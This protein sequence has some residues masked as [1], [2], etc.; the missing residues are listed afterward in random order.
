MT[1]AWISPCYAVVR[2]ADTQRAEPVAHA[3]DGAGA[4]EV[5]ADAAVDRAGR[6]GV[7]ADGH[8]AVGRGAVRAREDAVQGTDAA[9][10]RIARRAEAGVQVLDEAARARRG[11]ADHEILRDQLTDLHRAEVQRRSDDLAGSDLI[12]VAAD[13]DHLATHIGHAQSVADA[14]HRTGGL[15]VERHGA[16]AGARYAGVDSDRH[17]AGAGVVRA[18]QPPA[19][20]ADAGG[21]AR[22]RTEAGVQVFAERARRGR[23]G[24]CQHLAAASADALIG[25]NHRARYRVAGGSVVGRGAGRAGDGEQLRARVLEVVEDVHALSGQRRED[26]GG[27]HRDGDVARERVPGGQRSPVAGGHAVAGQ[28]RVADVAAVHAGLDRAAQRRAGGAD[29]GDVVG[30][31]VGAHAHVADHERRRRRGAV[32]DVR[33]GDALVRIAGGDEA[34]AGT[35]SGDVRSPVEGI[36]DAEVRVVV[37]GEDREG[38]VG[39]HQVAG[40][41]HV[42]D[43]TGCVMLERGAARHLHRAGRTLCAADKAHRAGVQVERPRVVE[44]DPE[45]DGRE[46]V[47][48]FVV[49]AV[50][51]E[52]VRAADVV[53]DERRKGIGVVEGSVVV[54]RRPVPEADRVVVVR[55]IAAPRGR[56]VQVDRAAAHDGLEVGT[57]DRDVVAEGRSRRAGNPATGP[58]H[59]TLEGGI[60]SPHGA[61]AEDER[62]RVRSAVDRD[63]GIRADV[64]GADLEDAGTARRDIVQRVV[65]VAEFQLGARGDVEDTACWCRRR[66]SASCRH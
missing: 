11:V 4:G 49:G 2:E 66:S 47:G 61:A 50:V 30:V 17:A 59:R 28:T 33:P 51:V 58:G 13:V 12:H 29:V 52:V 19:D 42:A 8:G 46:G 65:A 23:V 55:G 26:T 34:V 39:K 15:I 35:G 64:L 5:D 6:R 43:G 40:R 45:I 32:A 38:P 41:D 21:I 10:A 31:R 16:A 7:D 53:L 3:V 63:E 44:D 24:N 22:A 20:R 57:G 62:R 60:G 1:L 37:V 25:E 36:A 18:G 54:D 9:D 56:R 27:G 14:A 48:L